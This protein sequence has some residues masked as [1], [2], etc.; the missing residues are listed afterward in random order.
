MSPYV[1]SLVKMT[2]VMA[3][4]WIY[5]NDSYHGINP[6][7]SARLSAAHA[8]IMT[9]KN[10]WAKDLGLKKKIVNNVSGGWYGNGEEDICSNSEDSKYKP[11]T[12]YY[13]KKLN[14]NES[15]KAD[16]SIK[17]VLV[18]C[19]KKSQIPVMYGFDIKHDVIAQRFKYKSKNGVYIYSC[20]GNKSVIIKCEEPEIY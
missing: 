7:R 13:K 17:N 18:T 2:Y 10:N 20:K 11:F 1:H 3:Q 6:L 12:Q 9:L 15:I 4:H 19:N 8:R 14:A 16:I 5:D